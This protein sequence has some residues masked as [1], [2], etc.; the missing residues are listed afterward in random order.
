MTPHSQEDRFTR[1]FVSI[2][3]TAVFMAILYFCLRR[4]LDASTR[5][6]IGVAVPVG[7]VGF[8]IFAKIMEN[9][10]TPPGFWDD[11]G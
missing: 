3:G 10:D 4:F 1:W 8:W 9:I 6:S 2:I 11:R 5:V 7:L